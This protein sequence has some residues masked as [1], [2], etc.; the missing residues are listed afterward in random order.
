VFAGHLA[1][2]RHDVILAEAG[3]HQVDDE[4]TGDLGNKFVEK[5]DYHQ[6]RERRILSE[7]P[8][9]GPLIKLL[10][11]YFYALAASFRAV[12]SVRRATFVLLVFVIIVIVGI[13]RLCRV[14][15]DSENLVVRRAHFCSK[16]L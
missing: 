15:C 16:R 14:A 10:R 8:R 13:S 9:P 7:P 5:N 2:D 4:Q 11:E 6:L 1:P 3:I 12:P